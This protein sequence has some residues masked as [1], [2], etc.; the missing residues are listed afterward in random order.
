MGFYYIN[1]KSFYLL[2][3][4]GI[5]MLRIKL[6]RVEFK[7]KIKDKLSTLEISDKALYLAC[8]LPDNQFFGIFKYIFT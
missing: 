2:L 4:L 8:C 6:K 7:N 1:K 3:N 5:F